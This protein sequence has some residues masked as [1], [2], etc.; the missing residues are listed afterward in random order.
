[1]NVK[2]VK[3]KSEIEIDISFVFTIK[4]IRIYH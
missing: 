3:I 2:L 1:M 4:V